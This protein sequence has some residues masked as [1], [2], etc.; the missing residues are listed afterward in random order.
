[1]PKNITFT[2]DE[3]IE[4]AFQIFKEEGM[5]A[6]SARGIAAKLNSSTAP[7]YTSFSSM[8]EI[9]SILLGKSLEL[10]LKYT[11]KEYTPH[12]FLNIG[13]GMLEFAKE[14]RL[15][16][17]TLFIESNDHQNILEELNCK[18]LLQ[19][20]KE[21]SLEILS[22]EDLR[23]ILEKLTVYTH[24]LA[25]LICAG[26]MKDTLKENLIETLRDVGSD[27]IGATALKR[28]KLMEFLKCYKNGGN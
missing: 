22:E 17:R 6:I 9:K 10:L 28:G 13:V 1:M 12:I 18:N 4:A 19:M 24:G 14:Y 26:I 16:Y 8:D 25:S 5:A 23:G 21:K 3:I 20:E 7:V 2:K 27:I 15:I 11:E